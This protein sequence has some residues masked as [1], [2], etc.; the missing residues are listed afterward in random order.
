P[1]PGGPRLLAARGAAPMAEL[2][3]LSR[4]TSRRAA[5]LLRCARATLVHVGPLPPGRP[6]RVR[7]REQRTAGRHPQ[8]ARRLTLRDPSRQPARAEPEPR[9]RGRRR[10]LR[11]PAPARD[12]MTRLG[13]LVVLV[14]GAGGFLGACSPIPLARQSTFHTSDA[15]L[16]LTPVGHG[17]FI[18]QEQPTHPPLHPWVYPGILA[19]QHGPPR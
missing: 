11:G 3:R 1:A 9:H 15:D 4:G 18:L 6:A 8:R 16:G 2:G 14:A 13:A 19:S 10:A 7:G 17:P 12:G 5:A